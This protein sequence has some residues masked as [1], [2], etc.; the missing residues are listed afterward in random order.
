MQLKPWAPKPCEVAMEPDSPWNLPWA[1]SSLQPRAMGHLFCSDHNLSGG[2]QRTG[3]ARRQQTGTQAGQQDSGTQS[4]CASLA[5]SSEFNWGKHYPSLPLAPNPLRPAQG[6]KPY[7]LYPRCS[8]NPTVRGQRSD[9]HRIFFFLEWSSPFKKKT[10]VKKKTHPPPNVPPQR[11]REPTD[12][13]EFNKQQYSRSWKAGLDVLRGAETL[14]GGC[15][16]WYLRP[17]A[18]IS[19]GVLPLRLSSPPPLSIWFI[20][21]F[22]SSRWFCKCQFETFLPL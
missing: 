15:C 17:L 16:P 18:P 9:L 8:P 21:F 5:Y 20:F 19:P 3:I 14:R 2:D 12:T 13:L 10:G 4:R 7:S 1:L 22:N 11:R 6:I